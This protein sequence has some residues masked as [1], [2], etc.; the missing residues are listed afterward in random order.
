MSGES[1][2]LFAEG[3]F[4]RLLKKMMK[5]MKV[6][7]KTKRKMKKREQDKPLIS[8]V[9]MIVLHKLTLTTTQTPLGFSIHIQLKKIPPTR[10]AGVN[11]NIRAGQH[12]ANSTSRINMVMKNLLRLLHSTQTLPN[13]WI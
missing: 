1:T 4:L 2:N 12:N 11:G 8:M 6:K 7:K 5:V 10:V 9:E 3:M 13:C